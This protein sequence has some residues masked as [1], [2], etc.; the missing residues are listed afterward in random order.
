MTRKAIKVSVFIMAPIMIG[1]A[2]CAESIVSLILTDKWLPSVF[3][4][5]V[6]CIIY[7]FYPI[8]TANLN[9][10]RAVGRSDLFLKLEIEKKMIGF[11]ILILTMLI[12][13]KA[14]AIGLVIASILSQIINA[15]P[16]K[17]LLD[18]GYVEQLKDILP[19]IVLAVVMGLIIYPIQLLELSKF[20]T[21]SIQII[22]GIIVYNLEAK[23]FHLDTFEYLVRLIKVLIKRK[24]FNKND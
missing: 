19:S 6:F 1:L 4:L 11:I 23:I 13:V 10:I 7:M 17:K 12:S 18:Y 20:I 2:I 15:S 3:Y 21:L 8:H 5:R 16:N 22:I 9:A 24:E 14:M